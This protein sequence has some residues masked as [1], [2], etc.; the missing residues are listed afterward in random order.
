LSSRRPFPSIR[1]SLCPRRAEAEPVLRL[2]RTRSASHCQGRSSRSQNKT[3]KETGGDPREP[4]SLP[5]PHGQYTPARIIRRGGDGRPDGVSPKA[6]RQQIFS[7]KIIIMN[8]SRAPSAA[9]QPGPPSGH[10]PWILH[11]HLHLIH[12]LCQRLRPPA[13]QRTPPCQT[14][15]ARNR[16]TFSSRIFAA[17]PCLL[18]AGRQK[19]QAAGSWLAPM[20]RAARRLAPL[21]TTD[22]WSVQTT[23][24]TGRHLVLWSVLAL[25]PRRILASWPPSPT[26]VLF[27]SDHRLARR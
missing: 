16:C 13:R 9:E 26:P 19:K 23:P 11:P 22:P 25:R 14:T 12:L 8:K 6:R 5:G 24:C 7:D 3:V 15:H 20:P 10:T 2:L 21:S 17:C 4:T 27:A 18:R 1:R